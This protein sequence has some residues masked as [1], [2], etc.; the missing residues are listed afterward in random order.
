MG[1]CCPVPWIEGGC[2]VPGKVPPPLVLTGVPPLQLW[3]PRNAGGRMDEQKVPS[4]EK[5]AAAPGEP[6]QDFGD[7]ALFPLWW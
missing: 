5:D 4:E 2:R 7:L 6:V 1:K 3:P